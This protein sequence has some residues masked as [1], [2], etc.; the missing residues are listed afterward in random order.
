MS[1]TPKGEPDE[2][3]EALR[4]KRDKACRGVRAADISKYDVDRECRARERGWYRDRLADMSYEDLLWEKKRVER[5]Q[6]RAQDEERHAA[7]AVHEYES[8]TWDLKERIKR[9][10]TPETLRVLRCTPCYRY[11]VH[12]KVGEN[13]AWACSSCGIE[14][15]PEATDDV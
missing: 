9:G 5:W 14:V 12:L 11:I 4:R 15:T 13:G 8:A 3:L 10:A 1:G 6:E 7:F 2:M